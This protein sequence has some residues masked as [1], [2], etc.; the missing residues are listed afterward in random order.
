MPAASTQ[1][2]SP[3]AT[4]SSPA[5]RQLL[6]S[7]SPILKDHRKAHVGHHVL[8]RTLVT[9]HRHDLWLPVRI[10]CHAVAEQF[11]HESHVAAALT[12]VAQHYPQ[13]QAGV[14]AGTE[15]DAVPRQI[16]RALAPRI[17][18]SCV[19]TEYLRIPIGTR[20]FDVQLVVLRDD[21]VSDS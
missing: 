4:L 11:L 21:M 9:G 14:R 17:E 10:R 13:P 15:S 5:T 2:S 19:S 3:G 1:R 6:T 12:V 20:D 16:V 18:F 8:D 7:A